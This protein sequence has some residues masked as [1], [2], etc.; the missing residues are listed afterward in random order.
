LTQ[1]I[2]K[3][4]YFNCEI[5][6]STNILQSKY[7]KSYLESFNYIK[8]INDKTVLIK[9][10]TIL[11]KLTNL[12]HIDYIEVAILFPIDYRISSDINLSNFAESIGSKTNCR[13]IYEITNSNEYLLHYYLN[14]KLKIRLKNIETF[15]TS[16]ELNEAIRIMLKNHSIS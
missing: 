12:Q 13:L 4:S 8:I 16:N 5:K 1:L 15:K 9:Y 3:N 14:S 6:I 10:C 11:A 2:E 7:S